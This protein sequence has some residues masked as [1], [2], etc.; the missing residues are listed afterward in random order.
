MTSPVVFRRGLFLCAFRRQRHRVAGV[1]SDGAHIQAEAVTLA[2]KAA[3]IGNA[4]EDIAGRDEAVG[5]YGVLSANR[6]RRF[7]LMVEASAT[8]SVSRSPRN[9]RYAT[10]TWISRIN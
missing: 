7:W 6:R 8:L 5:N 9:Q 3:E 1:Q 10:L 4:V 2:V